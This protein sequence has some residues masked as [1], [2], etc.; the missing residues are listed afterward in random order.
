MGAMKGD[1]DLGMK[2]GWEEAVVI[3]VAWEPPLPLYKEPH[4][5]AQLK[6]HGC[7][8]FAWPCWAPHA[9]GMPA[10]RERGCSTG[11]FL[12]DYHREGGWWL[13]HGGRKECV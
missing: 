3:T 13:H 4:C 1:G 10:A 9:S 6:L 8:S 7:C 11:R 12:I 2:D 5:M